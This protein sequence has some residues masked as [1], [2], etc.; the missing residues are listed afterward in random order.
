MAELS[1]V[2]RYARALFATAQRGG[3]VQKV[4]DDLK[5]VDEALRAAPQLQRV[6]RAPTISSSRKRDLV[7]RLFAARV[8][9][10]T[11][12]FLGLLIR[13]RRETVLPEVYPEFKRLANEARNLL[14]V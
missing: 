10:L 2:R 13:R 6:L 14:P 8:S 5:L 4:E 9:E 1:V 11:V 3:V 12:K 7:D